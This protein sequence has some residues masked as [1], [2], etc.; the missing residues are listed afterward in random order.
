MLLKIEKKHCNYVYCY[1]EDCEFR[2]RGKICP[3]NNGFSR[4]FIRL[5]ITKQV[6]GVEKT[7][8]RKVKK[9]I[10]DLVSQDIGSR[11]ITY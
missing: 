1:L 3:K 7:I 4:P 11:V 10:Y 9:P 8:F 5:S 2:K 6:N